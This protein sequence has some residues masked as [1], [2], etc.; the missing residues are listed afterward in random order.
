[1]AKN[2]VAIVG[3]GQT[4][5]KTHYADK[6]YVEL[7]QEAAKLAL[8]DAGMEPGEID[9]VVYSMA[10]TQF[11][12]VNDC[13]RWATGHVWGKGKPYMRIHAGGATGGSALHAGYVHV[14]SGV[15]RS[16]LVVGADRVA[17]TPDA[18]HILNLIWDRFYEHD[19]ALNTVTM[20]ALAAQ[21]YMARY[22]TTE[23]Q[24]AKVVV[25]ARKNALGNPYAHLKGDIT[26]DD[27][28]G[29]PRVAY[30][31]KRF[32]ICPR[33]SG[34][35][36]VVLTNLDVAKQKSSKPAFVNGV[37]AIT[38]S[39]FMGDRMGVYSQTEFSDHDGEWIAGYEAYRQAGI[40]N[41][42]SQIQVAELYD[43][44]STFQFPIIEG[45]GFCGRGR[46]GAISDEGG[47]DLDAGFVAIGPSG[48]TLCTNP[49]GVTGLV[50]VVDAADQIRGKSGQNQVK[51]VKN[52]VATAAGGSTQFFTVTVLG[53]DHAP[54]TNVHGGRLQ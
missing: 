17:E 26:V 53:D 22:G 7:A 18:Q 31:Y 8:D 15:Y 6:T 37:S 1:M 20:T 44:F 47:W 41:P 23:E 24:F 34:A 9:A 45:L 48:G 42:A 38:H 2:A 32:D 27:V 50:R 21:R 16:V 49:I 46:A 25:R 36:A 54:H 4:K 19:F 14:A 12:G 33:S 40:T 52:A 43:P 35:A 3:T 13:D 30:P 51:N 5:F 28:M 39:V 10:P 29:S 11:M